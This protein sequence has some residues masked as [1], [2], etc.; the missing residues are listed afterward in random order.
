MRCACVCVSQTHKKR[1]PNIVNCH[2]RT[3]SKNQ[4]K[5]AGKFFRNCLQNV[6]D[7]SRGGNSARLQCIERYMYVRNGH[8]HIIYS[9]IKHQQLNFCQGPLN[10]GVCPRTAHQRHPHQCAVCWF[11]RAHIQ[12]ALVDAFVGLTFC[13]G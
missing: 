8:W 10:E 4:A 3:I 9:S 1:L 12:S 5:A 11:L 7:E 6:Y 2:C 13:T